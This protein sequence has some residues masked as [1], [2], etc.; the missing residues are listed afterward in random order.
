MIDPQN[1]EVL[2]VG[3]QE[4]MNQGIIVAK[5][6]STVEDVETLEIPYDQ[7]QPLE[8]PYDLSL[9]TI[10][11][12]PVFLLTITVPTLFPDGDTKANSW[13]YESTIYIDGKKVQEET[14]EIKEPTINIIETGGVTRSERIFAPIPPNIDNGGT[15]SQDKGK[16]I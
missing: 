2:K 13:I 10:F 15:S 4:L 1:C 9:M 14:L 8:I 16:K 3:I 12:D 6:I 7:V 11:V 5:H